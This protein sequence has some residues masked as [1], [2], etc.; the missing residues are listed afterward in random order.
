ME[1]MKKMLIEEYKS[2]ILSLIDANE[3]VKTLLGLFHP[4]E[5]CTTEAALVKNFAAITGKDCKDLLNLLRKRKILRIGAYSEYICLAG[6]EPIFDEITAE[7]SAQPGDL[8]EYFEKAVKDGNKAAV[9]LIELLLK[10]GEQGITGFTQYDI[11]KRD[12]PDMFSAAVFHS[13]EDDF[14]KENLC[15]YGKKHRREFL[16]LTQ[17]EEK[18][19]DVKERVRDWKSK[20]LAKMPVTKTLE[21]KIGDFITDTKRAAEGRREDF[22]EWSK[23]SPEEMDQLGGYFSGFKMDENFLFLT[24]DL[25][26]GRDTLHLVV[27]DSLSRFDVREKRVE[28]LMF[29]TAKAPRWLGR[30]EHIFREAYPRLSERKVAIAVPNKVAYSNFKQDLLYKI[31]DLLDIQEVSELR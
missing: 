21:K 5:G 20:E 14:I 30:F 18:I 16:K 3:D 27:T 15:V 2:T 19:K 28:P 31:V 8:S 1:V 22:V 26:V 7:F 23:F 9:K 17:S 24:G 13:L 10:I 29:V 11:I 12:M 6:Y 25:V 4:M